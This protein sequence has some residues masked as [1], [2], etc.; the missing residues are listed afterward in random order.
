ML[1]SLNFKKKR[2]VSSNK[3]E[4]G[5]SVKEK[6][7]IPLHCLGN[8]HIHIHTCT[9]IHTCTTQTRL[10]KSQV[11]SQGFPITL[12]D[13]NVSYQQCKTHWIT[14]IF[15]CLCHLLRTQWGQGNYGNYFYIVVK[16]IWLNI[17]LPYFFLI[18]PVKSFFDSFPQYSWQILFPT[19]SSAGSMRIQKHKVMRCVIFH[20]PFPIP[21]SP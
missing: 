12:S 6:N 9:N 16:I 15:P 5:W 8:K 2:Q 3:W 20:L 7:E 19:Q 11:H 21:T 18:Y 17:S 13:F 14:Q 10:V 1:F 4:W